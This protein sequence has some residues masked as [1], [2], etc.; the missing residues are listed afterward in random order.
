MFS[1]ANNLISLLKSKSTFFKENIWVIFTEYL[2]L[3]GVFIISVLYSRYYGTVA[4]GIFSYGTAISQI[5]ILGLGSAF[6]NLIM[7]DVGTNSRLNEVYLKKVLQIRGVIILLTLLVVFVIQFVIF[8]FTSNENFIFI[9][10][11]II[12][13][14]LDALC[15]TFYMVY[16]SLRIYKKYSFVKSL[17][18]IVTILLVTFSCMMHYSILF[19]YVILLSC[20]F[21]FFVFNFY[22]FHILKGEMN[23]IESP[24]LAGTLQNKTPATITF[25]YLAREIWPLLLSVVFFQAG[26]RIN[27][28][29]IF[30]LLGSI[31]LGVYSSG[32]IL[33]TCFTAA[34]PFMGIVLFPVLN[35]TFLENPEKLS[36]FILKI[37]PVIF[38]VGT[39]VML[40]CY[41]SIPIA[42]Q[43]MKN[44]PDYS[45]GI[46]SIMI[47]VVPFNY[48]IG[49][50]NS[51]FI[52][53]QKQKTGM[54]VT[55]IIMVVNMALV[56]FGALHFQIKGVAM[57]SVAGSIF[58]VTL[59][60]IIYFYLSNK[61]PPQRSKIAV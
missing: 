39:A 6:S 46:F 38:L 59:F 10:I 26:S 21:A 57:A 48:V 12:A 5:V 41:L 58:Q 43:L 33:I 11:L 7:R 45:P 52:I 51:L 40:V 56:Y 22:F 9:S 31:S 53:I 25:R 16:L 2:W 49:I 54:V 1:K 27:A 23:R 34:A 50:I 42:I 30:G 37:I 28:L 24:Q 8:P 17:H 20:S 35:K 29:I 36:K 18:T 13:K 3:F 15:D 47:W 44:L 4:L 14:G 61:R 32:L 60:V 55:F 19:T